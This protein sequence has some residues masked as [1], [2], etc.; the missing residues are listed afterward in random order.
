MKIQYFIQMQPKV[1]YEVWSIFKQ[2]SNCVYIPVC[3]EKG[4]TDP[5][6]SG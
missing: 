3:H 4:I 1:W 2:S 5:I 6:T